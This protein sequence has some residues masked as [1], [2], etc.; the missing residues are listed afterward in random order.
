MKHRLVGDH[1]QFIGI[2]LNKGEE[3]IAFDFEQIFCRGDLGFGDVGEAFNGTGLAPP[4]L[5]Y[6][7]GGHGMIGLK[8]KRGGRL[9]RVEIGPPKGRHRPTNPP[10]RSGRSWRRRGL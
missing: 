8:P 7:R 9:K 6:C 2:E 1:H 4:T 3:I 10:R 5:L